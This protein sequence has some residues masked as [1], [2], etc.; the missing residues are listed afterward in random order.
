KPCQLITGQ[1][2]GEFGSGLLGESA[3]RVFWIERCSIPGHILPQESGQSSS[4]LIG[5]LLSSVYV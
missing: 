4:L 2:V 1:H 5:N 3:W